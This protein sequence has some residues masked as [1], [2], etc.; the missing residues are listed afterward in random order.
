MEPALFLSWLAASMAIAAVAHSLNRP[1]LRWFFIAFFASPM[2][3]L[4]L[5]L[6]SVDGADAG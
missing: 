6:K 2:I 5:V 4:P 1:L 3:A